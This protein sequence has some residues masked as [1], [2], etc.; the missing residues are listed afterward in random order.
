VE[1]PVLAVDDH[2]HRDLG[3][4]VGGDLGAQVGPDVAG[5][6]FQVETEADRVV[7]VVL[8]VVVPA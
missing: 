2:V 1:A 8:D 6:H 3:L 5:G 7:A 4:G